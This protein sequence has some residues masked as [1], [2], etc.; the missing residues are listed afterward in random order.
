MIRKVKL[1]Q[2]HIAIDRIDESALLSQRVNQSDAAITNRLDSV[3]HFVL[4]VACPKHRGAR[5]RVACFSLV[6]DAS[7]NSFLLRFVL[8][9][10]VFNPTLPHLRLPTYTL[11]TIH[12]KSFRDD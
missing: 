8:L 12:S 5:F 11:S 4:N 10:S 6:P 1:Q 9:S 2:L 7:L 3:R